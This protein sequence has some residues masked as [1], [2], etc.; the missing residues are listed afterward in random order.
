MRKCLL[1]EIDWHSRKVDDDDD[2]REEKEKFIFS[3]FVDVWAFLKRIQSNTNE[4]KFIEDFTFILDFFRG[5]VLKMKQ[6]KTNSFT[7][8]LALTIEI[9][10]NHWHSVGSSVFDNVVIFLREFCTTSMV[11]H[12]IRFDRI[13]RNSSRKCSIEK[14]NSL[15]PF[16][17]VP[18]HS[19]KH[20]VRIPFDHSTFC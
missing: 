2:Q 5:T 18:I 9:F 4:W 3:Y 13:E 16:E 10:R 19:D 11:D 7:A 20:F 12:C 14:I 6:N 8:F 1:I 17:F 15:I